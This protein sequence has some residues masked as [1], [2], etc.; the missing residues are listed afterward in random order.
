[1]PLES[2]RIAEDNPRTHSP[3][4]LD[5]LVASISRLGWGQPILATRDGII[6]AGANRW[7]AGAKI[8]L[9]TVPVITLDISE[10]AATAL[11]IADNRLTDLGAWDNDLL[12]RELASLSPD[13][14]I[15]VGF[16]ADEIAV[17]MES[18]PAEPVIE[19]QDVDYRDDLEGRKKATLV[20]DGKDRNRIVDRLRAMKNEFPSLNYYL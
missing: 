17:I 14:A 13:L 9:K 6:I 16:S 12:S 15:A 8:G 18:L 1:M 4:A 3:A 10:E 11:R 5:A 7:R 2:L 20:F 19:M